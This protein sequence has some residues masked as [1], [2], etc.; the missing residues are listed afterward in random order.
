ML[1]AIALSGCTTTPPGQA[2]PGSCDW[3]QAGALAVTVTDAQGA[4][5]AEVLVE[6][7]AVGQVPTSGM[8]A[9]LSCAGPSSGGKLRTN[10]QGQLVFERL[11]P[12]DY[13]VALVDA[14]APA[15]GYVRVTDKQTAK[16]TLAMGAVRP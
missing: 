4:P 9:A 10:G 6:V 14:P 15:D 5:A 2:G 1:A 11:R 13:R 3:V 8:V 12:G 7:K 16:I